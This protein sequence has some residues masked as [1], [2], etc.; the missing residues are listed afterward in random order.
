MPTPK[1]LFAWPEELVRD[2]PHNV[3]LRHMVNHDPD[4]LA[5]KS[6]WVRL[7]ETYRNL[8]S[9]EKLAVW[10]RKQCPTAHGEPVAIECD[11]FWV[12]I[13]HIMELDVELLDQHLAPIVDAFVSQK[14]GPR[15]RRKA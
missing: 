10:E 13:A 3:T 2:L 7:G 4:R 1:A 15:G 5:L 14:Q 9:K 12:K 6:G 8:T 11:E